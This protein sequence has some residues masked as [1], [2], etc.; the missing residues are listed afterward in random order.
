MIVCFDSVGGASGDMILAALLDLGA[1]IGVIRE[2]TAGLCDAAFTINV[3]PRSGHGMH[4]TQVRVEVTEVGNPHRDLMTIRKII[5]GSRLPPAVQ[6]LSLRTFER[7]AVA[8]AKVHNTTPDR[9]HFHEAGAVDSIVDIVASNLALHLLGVTEV[10]VGPLPD[11]R[12]TMECAH[13]VMPIPVPATAELLAGMPVVATQEPFELVTP[14]GAALLSTWRTGVQPARPI[15]VTRIS[16]AFGHRRLN[17]RPNLLRAR[18][19][20]YCDAAAGADT[21]TCLV[22]ECNIDDMN[23]ELIGGLT[24]DLLAAGALDVFTQP[25]QMKKQRPGIL[26]TVLTDPA[27]REHLID[28]VFRGTTTFGIREYETRR[29]VLA[30]RHVSVETPYGAVRIK[31]GAWRG[32]DITFSPEYEDCLKCAKAATVAVRTVY[33]AAQRAARQTENRN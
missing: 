19:A 14:T 30:R 24:D 3:T 9:V 5:E 4:G 1:D 21:D 7:L 23:P 11:G 29:T 20:E 10:F 26:F 16:Y 25:I 18:L 13:G 31:I 33:E 17:T 8:E 22:L 28:L 15:S 2:M 32:E 12:G 6:A 27:R